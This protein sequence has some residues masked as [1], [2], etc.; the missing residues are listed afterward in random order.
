MNKVDIDD[1][2]A[3]AEL[4]TSLIA[5]IEDKIKEY[6]SGRIKICRRGNRAYYYLTD[7]QSNSKV[8]LLKKA[9]HELI[10]NLVQKSYLEK[11]LRTSKQET[12]AIREFID[13]YPEFVAEDI[14][15][16]ISEER[17]K[18]AKPII[19]NDEQYVREWQNI[20]YVR[21]PFNEEDPVFTTMRGERVR[22][23]SEVLIA[24]RLWA[25]NIP[26]K[27]ECPVRVKNKIIHPDFTILRISDRKQVYLEHCGKMDDPAYVEKR[28]VKRTN[29]YN[30]AGIVQGRNLFF[31]FESLT[32]PLNLSV[33]DNLINENFR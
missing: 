13:H 24:D 22:S 20:P 17:R 10:N 6:P 9:D 15:D 29:D 33:L 16:H 30:S 14:Y 32:S 1:L 26:Y 5:R 7:S 12:A 27:Y 25:N 2:K 4:I 23:K 11:V 21:K 18:I 19:Q 28:V 8:I 3:R 31:T